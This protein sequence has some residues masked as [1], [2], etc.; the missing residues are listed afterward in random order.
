[1]ESRMMNFL[2]TEVP[3]YIVSEIKRLL[4]IRPRKPDGR[5]GCGIPTGM[6]LLAILDLFG[7]LI[8]NDRKSN[9][10]DTRGNL[11][12][13]FSKDIG[14][15]PEEYGEEVD[16]LIDL[17]R[18]GM[19]HQ[20]FPKASGIIKAKRNVPL[21]QTY[22]GFRHLNVDRM[23][24]DVLHMLDKL[25]QILSQNVQSELQMQMSHRLDVLAEKD[26]EKLHRVKK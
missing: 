11:S 6:F 5:G 1:M 16:V 13:I 7:Y 15:F 23:G 3:K 12:A 24:E 21:F 10:K 19:M 18:H 25:S 14:L 4:K 20:V 26:Y 8:R 17:Y 22:D 9:P 2:S